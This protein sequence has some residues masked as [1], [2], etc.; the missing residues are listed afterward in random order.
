MTLN[1]KGR[2]LDRLG[3]YLLKFQ[4]ADMFFFS[5]LGRQLKNKGIYPEW[6]YDPAMMMMMSLCGGVRL[7]K[8]PKRTQQN[9]MYIVVFL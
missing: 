3:R 2:C 8:P 6:G 4:T 5:T 7:I 1:L 9:D